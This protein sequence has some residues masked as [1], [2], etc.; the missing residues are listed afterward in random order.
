MMH[1]WKT[2]QIIV[3]DLMNF[4]QSKNI[5]VTSQRVDF[6]LAEGFSVIGY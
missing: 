5:Y 6:Y 2:T 3:Y 4:S 1:T